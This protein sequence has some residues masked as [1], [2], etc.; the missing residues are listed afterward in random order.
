MG[1]VM[2]ATTIDG[3]VFPAVLSNDGI[4][5]DS[6]TGKKAFADKWEEITLAEYDKLCDAY[7]L[8]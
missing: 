8:D 3:T 2:K 7:G 6:R 5:W 1:T 4:L